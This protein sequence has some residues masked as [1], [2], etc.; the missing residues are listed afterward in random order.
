MQLSEHFAL[1]EFTKSATATRR[2]LDN[3]P[4]NP[5]VVTLTEICERV[6]EPVR[7]HFKKAVRI[8]SGYRSPELNG[9]IGGSKSSQH[10]GRG[11]CAAVDFEILGVSNL[12]VARWV[13]DNLDGEF[14]QLILE[15]HDP[16]GDPNSGW[17]H[18]S[19]RPE[20]RSQTLTIGKSGT[21]AGLPE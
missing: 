15:F 21:T 9:L 16:Q 10:M 14:D 19:R 5:V 4:P 8:N 17:V 6:L 12:E 20:N 3:T 18:V 11:G 2:G 7:A 13:K 1:W